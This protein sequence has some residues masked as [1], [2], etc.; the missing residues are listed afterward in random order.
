LEKKTNEVWQWTDLLALRA[1]CHYKIAHAIP[2]DGSAT[3]REIA[4]TTQQ[5]EPIITRLIRHGMI[6]HIFDEY[7]P[8]Q[9]CHTAASR[10]LVTN[11]GFGDFIGFQTEDLA[12]ASTMYIEAVAKFADSPEPNE[13]A[14]TLIN[15]S[16]KQFYETLGQDPHRAKRFGSGMQYFVSNDTWDFRHLFPVFDWTSVDRPG[17]VG[18]DI[19]GGHG[20]ISQFIA[21]RTKHLKFVV[22]DLAHVAAKGKDILPLEFK[23]RIEFMAQDFLD[24]QMLQGVDVFI[25]RWVLH[26]W[27][28]KYCIQILRNLIPAMKPGTKVLL[29][30]FVLTREPEK[31]V[32]RK[33]ALRLDMVMATG[34]NGRER[35]AE[36]F[37]M[38]LAA[39]DE[40]YVMRSVK[41]P[42]A[43]G[44]SL[45]EVDWKSSE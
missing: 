12:P 29:Y 6:N 41:C 22:Q 42:I 1:I 28:D 4:T 20:H 43:S 31:D 2:L 37:Q 10:L 34:F 8:G 25:I 17:F 21:T 30:E 44:L 5:P 23:N 39:A 27:S 35:T 26:N 13:T 32:T 36:G 19:G 18:V 3:Y 11:S 40:R 45:I 9:V 15:N 16:T 33:A 38:L 7:P 14:F 24:P